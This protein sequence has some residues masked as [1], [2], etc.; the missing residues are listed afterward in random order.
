[1]LAVDE[2]L[3]DYLPRPAPLFR[4]S[5]T[6]LAKGSNRTVDRRR[7]LLLGRH[8]GVWFSPIVKIFLNLEEILAEVDR[9]ASRLGQFVPRR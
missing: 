5:R 4:P 9:T 1:M 8:A 2:P 7:S 3:K 6:V